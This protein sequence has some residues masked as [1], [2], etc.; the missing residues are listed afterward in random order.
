[1]HIANRRSGGGEEEKNDAEY[2]KPKKELEEYITGIDQSNQVNII[3]S[4][5]PDIIEEELVK[6]LVG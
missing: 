6:Y 2:L 3:T 4:Y 5:N 1:M